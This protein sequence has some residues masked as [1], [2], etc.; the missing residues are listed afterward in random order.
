MPLR[1]RAYQPTDF[2]ALWALDQICFPPDISYSRIELRMY[3][4]LRTAFCIVAEIDGKIVGFVVMDSR[5]RRPAYMVTIDVA[6]EFR[7]SGVAS[8]LLKEV[9]S[10]LRVR[11]VDRIRLEVAESNSAAIRFY[12]RHG[13]SVIGRKPGYYNGRLDALS[14]K[15]ELAQS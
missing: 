3:L 15:K 5:D 12:E 9:E 14:M 8:A 10:R 2:D 1:L 13:F 7:K 6:P 4:S 11:G